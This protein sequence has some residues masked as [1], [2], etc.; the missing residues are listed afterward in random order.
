MYTV[1]FSGSHN[2]LNWKKFYF[3]FA[4]YRNTVIYQ[5]LDTWST[6]ILRRKGIFDPSSKSV[7]EGTTHVKF[8]YQG[9]MNSFYRDPEFRPISK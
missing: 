7:F 3:L 6:S 9:S 5:N 2:Q 4:E 8:L 1:N